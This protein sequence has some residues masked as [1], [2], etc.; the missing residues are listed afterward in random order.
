MVVCFAA[1][2]VTH[3]EARP[4]VNAYTSH[5]KVLLEQ[6][7]IK[8]GP[9]TKLKPGVAN[10]VLGWTAYLRDAMTS[11]NQGR[12]PAFSEDDLYLL[13]DG[14]KE[15]PLP[16]RLLL[17]NNEPSL[18]REVDVVHSFWQLF[19]SIMHA[20]ANLAREVSSHLTG[21]RARATERMDEAFAE[22][23]LDEATYLFNA[24]PELNRREL[25]AKVAMPELYLQADIA[26]LVRTISFSSCTLSWM[27][28]RIVG[29]RLAG[30]HPETTSSLADRGLGGGVVLNSRGEMMNPWPPMP[31]PSNDEAYWRRLFM[32]RRRV[33]TQSFRASRRVASIIGATIEQGYSLSSAWLDP[34]FVQVLFS[35]LAFWASSIVNMPTIEQGGPHPDFAFIDKLQDL[36][37]IKKG[38]F[39]VGWM[40]LSMAGSADWVKQEIAKT[41][42]AQAE[43]WSRKVSRYVLTGRSSFSVAFCAWA[44]APWVC[45][46]RA[47]AGASFDKPA[48]PR[49]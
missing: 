3:S 42:Q 22:R 30:R 21:P 43:H 33:Y 49:G 37:W 20:I 40:S 27:L 32:L 15:I 38:C 18:E 5:T 46:G 39:S 44:D 35:R 10:T 11:A 1:T 13:T 12:S 23:F 45:D 41:E 26:T 16:L 19:Q 25:L 28:N 24:L 7:G 31:G 29:Q 6:G 8:L 14:G 34:R 2:D 9:T 17:E 48:E 36:D 4:F 47:D